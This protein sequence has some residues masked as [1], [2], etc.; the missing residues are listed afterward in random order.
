M[1][2]I[3]GTWHMCSE[4]L[5]LYALCSSWCQGSLR[6][7][8]V[9][10][11]VSFKVFQ[12]IG[13]EW[14]FMA[15][16][17]RDLCI[18]LFTPHWLPPFSP[19]AEIIIVC[20]GGKKW[21]V[22]PTS[23]FQTVECTIITEAQGEQTSDSTW[24]CSHVKSVSH[25]QLHPQRFFLLTAF[26]S[27]PVSDTNW[28]Q[29]AAKTTAAAMVL[30]VRTWAECFILS[31]LDKGPVCILPILNTESTPSQDS[32]LSEKWKSIML[33]SSTFSRDPTCLASETSKWAMLTVFGFLPVSAQASIQY[34][35]LPATS[36]IHCLRPLRPFFWTQISRLLE[37]V[38]IVFFNSHLQMKRG[39]VQKFRMACGMQ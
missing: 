11:E 28:Q 36:N 24:T 4:L 3:F 26:A 32:F 2:W 8:R 17:V 10:L 19:E 21:T 20:A 23:P 30:G 27:Q 9:W 38:Q 35:T 39:S 34:S 33:D 14:Y 16:A 22:L 7:T 31:G 12:P 25:T 5:Q 29:P 13:N 1:P 15:A 6:R 37:I 18:L